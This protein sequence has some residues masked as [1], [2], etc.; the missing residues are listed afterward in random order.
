[1]P[2]ADADEPLAAVDRQGKP[3]LSAHVPVTPLNWW[4][5]VE[6]P[7]AD[8]YAPLY[9]SITRSAY[10]LLAALALSIFASLLFARRMVVPIR[11]LQDGAMRIGGGELTKRIVIKTNDEFE[12]LGDEFNKMA[13]RLQ[14]SYATLEHKVEERTR[15]LRACQSCQVPFFGCSEPRFATAVARI[16]SIGC[17]IARPDACW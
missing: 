6:L 3:V 12:A 8:A 13:A 9:N 5:F 14:E 4:V 17:A 1:M 10:L 11:V 2:E 16:G 15:Q 7:I